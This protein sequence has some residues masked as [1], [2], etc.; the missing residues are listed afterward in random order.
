MIGDVALIEPDRDEPRVIRAAQPQLLDSKHQFLVLIAQLAS[1]T[2]A[3]E[4]GDED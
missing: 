2:A 1:Q 4:A 3:R